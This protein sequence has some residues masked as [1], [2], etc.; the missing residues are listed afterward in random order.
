MSQICDLFS[1]LSKQKDY[2]LPIC[3][4]FNQIKKETTKL[5]CFLL[6]IFFNLK[7]PKL[8]RNLAAMLLLS[9]M[10]LTVLRHF[11]QFLYTQVLR[12]HILFC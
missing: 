9:N 4:Y 1:A 7:I 10:A 2:Q 5:F 3:C 12:A 6:G 11:K 8:L